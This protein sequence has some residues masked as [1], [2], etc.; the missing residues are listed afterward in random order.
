MKRDTTGLVIRISPEVT[1]FLRHALPNGVTILAL[2]FGLTALVYANADN[3]TGA[4]ACILIAAILD[5]CD[6]RV[7]RA[8][9]CA[10]KF[11]AELDSLSDVVCFGAAPAFILHQWGLAAYG[12]LGW[13]ACLSLAAA[14]ALRLARFNVMV[15]APGRP[16]WAG[17]YFTGVPAPAGAFLS[18]LPVYAANAGV[19]AP[20]EAATLA[21]FAVPVVAG[22]M[23]STWPS[24]SAKA[25]SRKALRLLFLPTLALMAAVVFGLFFAPW[26]TLTLSAVAYLWTLPLSK[27]RHALHRRRS[28]VP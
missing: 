4:I 1:L 28:A 16:S 18:F 3:I 22:L 6:G 5:A 20:S 13:L 24:F 17:N 26:L 12:N 21:L 11:G 7:A 10:S 27:W 23:V 15:E 25:I 2:C 14:A 8:T 19:L 9:G